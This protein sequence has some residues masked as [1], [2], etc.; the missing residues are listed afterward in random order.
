MSATAVGVESPSGGRVSPATSA[1]FVA[2]LLAISVVASSCFGA[3]FVM[4]PY[5]MGHLGGSAGDVGLVGGLYQGCYVVAMLASAA[6]FDRF[7]ARRMAVT[8]NVLLTG[9]VLLMA[10]AQRKEMLLAA[11]AVYGVATAWHWPLVMGLISTGAEG[12][13][14]NRRLG[15]FNAAWS[16][17]L[18]IGP[19]VGGGLY[20]ADT[21]TAF[22]AVAALHAICVV[23]FVI[24]TAPERRSAAEITTSPA[25]PAAGAK[26]PAAAASV[27]SRASGDPPGGDLDPRT[28]DFRAMARLALVCS[29]M[30]VGLLRY[31]LPVVA[32][33][34]LGLPAARFSLVSTSF[35]A[36]QTAGFV[37]LGL[38]AIWHFR[39]GW[40]WFA[41]VVLAASLWIGGG[42]DSRGGLILCSVI[43]G[44]G[45]SFLYASHL[46]YGVSGGLRRAR[47]MT[48]HEILLSLG[49]MAGSFGGGY[50]AEIYG[51]RSPYM[52]FG[53]VLLLAV[54]VEWALR[55]RRRAAAVTP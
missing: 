16:G 8:G 42:A 54:G 11:V 12:A 22:V 34:H 31:H 19:F 41:H 48:L 18:I 47:L 40:F 32:Q 4:L 33:N 27:S 50:T 45:V 29:Y 52:L 7:N 25:L 37:L 36:A 28:A 21:S 30:A 15:R 10:A 49:F 5:R 46:Y 53:V 55:R 24:M 13:A 51:R 38:S 9:A 1:W 39:V 44:L 2:T 20:S 6:L 23:L 43:A 3:M 17:G 26:S 14:L 35:N